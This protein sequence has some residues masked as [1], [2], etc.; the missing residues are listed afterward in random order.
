MHRTRDWDEF[1]NGRWGDAGSPSFSTLDIYHLNLYRVSPEERLK[2]WGTPTTISD[3]ADVFVSYLNGRVRT[4]PWNNTQLAPEA[5]AIF[6]QLRNI[7]SRG[8]FTVNSQPR[9]NACSSDHPVFGWGP[10]GGFVWQKA[11]VEFFCSPAHL[12]ELKKRL[13]KYS[14][15]QLQAM[16]KKGDHFSNFS[17]VTAVTWGV[18]PGNEVKQPTVVDPEVFVIWKDEAFALWTSEWSDL[19]PKDSPSHKLIEEIADTF[20]LVN[21]LDND[22][23]SDNIFAIF[24]DIIEKEAL[25]EAMVEESK[26]EKIRKLEEL[27]ATLTAANEKLT[28]EKAALEKK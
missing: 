1:P 10:N 20:Y 15:L 21:I 16:S 12:E 19:Y 28:A 25:A 4:L 3:V 26:K 18:F 13:P 7:N 5:S 17:T 24:H 6:S 11:Y 22:F 2:Q 23:T 27:V 14:N 8:F 9:V